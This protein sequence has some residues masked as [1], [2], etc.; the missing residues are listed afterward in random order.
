M[1]RIILLLPLI[2]VPSVAYTQPSIN[3]NELKYDFGVV[4]QDE[5][6]GHVFE[7]MNNGDKDLIIEKVTA[8]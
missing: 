7:F 3:F 2:L 8:S 5:K 1:I 6:A 4:I